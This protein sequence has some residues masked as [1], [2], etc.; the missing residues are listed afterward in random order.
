ME[1]SQVET[2]PLRASK[3]PACRY[4][5]V[6]VSWATSSASAGWRTMVSASP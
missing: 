1:S 2:R 4:T 6:K 5:R 3:L